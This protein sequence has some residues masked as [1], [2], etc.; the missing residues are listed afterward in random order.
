MRGIH[1]TLA[2]VQHVF[3]ARKKKDK[4]SNQFVAQ[5]LELAYHDL[6]QVKANRL[7]AEQ[8]LMLNAAHRLFL[9]GQK[10]HAVA[11]VAIEEDV[12]TGRKYLAPVTAYHA[13]EAKIR[14]ILK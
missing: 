2:S 6:S 1:I 8:A 4:S 10:F 12:L 11:I 9:D 7:H 5:I 14:G 3:S 13:T